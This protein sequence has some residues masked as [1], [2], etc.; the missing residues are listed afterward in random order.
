LRH[1]ADLIPR[2]CAFSNSCTRIAGQLVHREDPLSTQ[3]G[4]LSTHEGAAMEQ[5][6]D[7]GQP[8]NMSPMSNIS[9][10]NR[11]PV[12][13]DAPRQSG[14]RRPR[15]T[16]A[17]P[18]GLAH[19]SRVPYGAG[20]RLTAGFRPRAGGRSMSRY[21]ST[22]PRTS[23]GHQAVNKSM[24]SRVNDHERSPWIRQTR[25]AL[26]WRRSARTWPCPY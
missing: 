21:R 8:D 14:P 19:Q 26:D 1:R 4:R 5:D 12:T 2:R 9:Q 11:R 25:C 16:P 24:S 6:R 15:R 22:M 13:R 10:P 20:A 23:L 18:H 7:A 17:A 3:Y